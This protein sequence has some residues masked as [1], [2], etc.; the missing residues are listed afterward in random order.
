MMGKGVFSANTTASMM[1]VLGSM[2]GHIAYGAV[3]GEV[4]G[5]Q[6]GRH[7]YMHQERHP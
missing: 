2:M 6:S 4:A 5:E 7:A 1:M 3:L